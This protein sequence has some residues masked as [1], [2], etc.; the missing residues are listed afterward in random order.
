M[1]TKTFIA[2]SLISHLCFGQEWSLEQTIKPKREITAVSVDSK[3][4]IYLGTA[5]GEVIRYTNTGEEDEYFSALNNSSVS[6]IQAWNR[7][8]VF[9]F[10][11]DQQT[12]SI[13]DRFTT[14]PKNINLSDLGLQYAWLFAPGIDN[15]Y[16]AL[17]TE[18]REL[19]KY[20]DQN[21][22]RLFS[23]PIQKDIKINDPVY[24]RA[25]KNLIILIDHKSGL[26]VFDQ[27]GD[28]KGNIKES[29]IKH[30]DIKEGLAHC[31]VA[32]ELVAIDLF[33]MEVMS[34]KKAPESGAFWSV[35]I[36][37]D[38]YVFFTRERAEIYSLH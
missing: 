32:D 11:R 1:K 3:D 30:L 14:T 8:K 20:D 4:L 5:G 27:F 17:S 36:S 15:S 22:S 12:A 18:T 38:R 19:I 34:R 28:F 16:W 7:L 9:V 21:L 26:W 25:Y 6:A 2:L 23:I 13:L 37:G 35:V 29:G 10:Y 24:L 33:K 31:V